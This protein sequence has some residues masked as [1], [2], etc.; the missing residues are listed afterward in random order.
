[1]SPIVRTESRSAASAADPRPEDRLAEALLRCMGRWGLAKTT[2]EDIAREAG[3][4]R[5]TVYRI[6]PGGKAAIL[7]AA[8]R[9]EVLRLAE[10]VRLE[11]DRT[12]DLRDCAVG[13]LHCASTFL[14]Q[15]EAL[16]FMRE[17]EPVALEQLLGFDHLD[18]LFASA[19]EVLRPSLARFLDDRDALDLGVWL[20]RIVVSYLITPTPDVDLTRVEDARRL[21][22][23]FVLP[24][25]RP[26]TPADRF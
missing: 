7:D 3:M 15:H 23:A 13:V 2:V 11:I 24:G 14:D 8:A 20:A 12:G 16:R 4:S 26:Q 22:D 1:M 21:V 6:V 17:H 9:N 19:G 25:L 18:V 5:A 10:L